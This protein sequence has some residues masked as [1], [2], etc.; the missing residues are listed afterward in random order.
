MKSKKALKR[1][2]RI[3]KML[4]GVL[5][6]YSS[7]AAHV[8][9]H[10]DAAKASLGSARNAMKPAKHAPSKTSKTKPVPLAPPKKEVVEKAATKPAKPV[11]SKVVKTKPKAKPVKATKPVLK[12]KPVV[13]TKPK[14]KPK[15]KA[16][17]KPRPAPPIPPR[18][19]SPVSAKT[20]PVPPPA[21]SEPA[22]ADVPS[23]ELEPPGPPS[24][25]PET[26]EPS[27]TPTHS[28]ADHEHLPPQ[29]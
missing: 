2:N 29:E 23:P 25:M 27:A 9:E 24:D 14:S 18:K 20:K 10:L 21:V 12:P 1:L 26:P 22:P 3:E 16:K 28:T 17:P 19:K 13:K 8:R 5:D 4:G 6:A 7:A 11:K 15:P